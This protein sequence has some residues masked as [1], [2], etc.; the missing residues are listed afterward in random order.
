MLP[1]PSLDTAKVWNDITTNKTD[2]AK[3]QK[4]STTR[5]RQTHKPA[6]A[7]THRVFSNMGF[8]LPLFFS[9]PILT[10]LFV[11]DSVAPKLKNLANRIFKNKTA[12]PHIQ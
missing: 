9:F 2:T 12:E 8:L 6:D 4:T 1:T 3:A 11:M 7:K 10:G 5:P